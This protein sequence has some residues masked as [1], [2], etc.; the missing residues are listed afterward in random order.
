MDLV[1]MDTGRLYNT[2]SVKGC[3]RFKQTS[4][5]VLR[6]ARE[7][8]QVIE[9]LPAT[10]PELQSAVQE[11]LSRHFTQ[12]RDYATRGTRVYVSTGSAP[13]MS[14]FFAQI[15]KEIGGCDCGC[16][17]SDRFVVSVG[18]DRMLSE[19]ARTILL[20]ACTYRQ[21]VV[22][23]AYEHAN[24]HTNRSMAAFPADLWTTIHQMIGNDPV[25]D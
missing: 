10:S 13:S 25:I 20:Q 8:L 2:F 12:D 21:H 22:S 17:D 23:R 16:T 19:Y 14:R 4:D 6:Q 3:T 1:D 24:R 9:T 7:S 18:R 5:V 11:I 15:E